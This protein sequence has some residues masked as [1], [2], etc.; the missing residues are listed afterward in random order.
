MTIN[1]EKPHAQFKD[2]SGA[3]NSADLTFTQV[4]VGGY[5]EGRA[6]LVFLTGE[7]HLVTAGSHLVS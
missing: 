6:G 7:N 3:M 1:E 2:P 4:L 5:A